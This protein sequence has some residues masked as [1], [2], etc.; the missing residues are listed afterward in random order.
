MK[1]AYFKNRRLWGLLSVIYLVLITFPGYY[2]PIQAGLDPSWVYG[3]NYLAQSD[4]VF[5]QDVVFTYG[6]LG[7]LIHPLNIGPNLTY[8]VALWGIIHSLFA[9]IL[10]YFLFRAKRLLPF[11]LFIIAYITTSV[12]GWINLYEYHFLLILGL[13]FCASFVDNNKMWYVAAPLGG[14]LAG[15]SL[16]M[17]LNLGLAALTMIIA[18]GLIWIIKNRQKAWQVILLS[19]GAYLLM[20]I[21]LSKV[22]FQ[23]FQNSIGWIKASLD[24]VSGYSAAM[25]IIGPR[26]HLF[27]GVL[28]LAIYI[29]LTFLLLRKRSNLFYAAFIFIV[30]IFFAFKHSFVRQDGHVLI[31][32]LFLLAVFS[33]L[34][35][36]T[37]GRKELRMV[38]SGFLAAL[39]LTL[40]VVAAYHSTSFSMAGDIISGGRG[41]SNINSVVRLENVRAQLDQQGQ[42]NLEKDRLPTEWVNEIKNNDNGMADA[43]PWEICYCPANNLS[44]NPNPVL[45]TYSAYTS[46]LDNWSASHYEGNNAPEF[47]IAEFMDIDGRHPL[48]G[49]PATWRNI[50]LNY[51]L[52]LKDSDAGRLLLERKTQPSKENVVVINRGKGYTNQWISVPRSNNLLFLDI[53]MQLT[54]LGAGIKTLFRIPPVYMDLIYDS[55]RGMSYRIIPD[56]A[57][58]GLLINFLP[59]N[60]EELSK[61]FTGV[62]ND[63]VAQ[64]RISGPGTIYYG[65]EISLTWK[66]ISYAIKFEGLLQF[67][68]CRF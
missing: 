25:S 51:E 60:A 17:K 48:L 57:K 2:R 53:D 44:W 30:P 12:I 4:Y 14:L 64:F 9:S 22:Y 26:I 16:F 36:N 47:L 34:I 10:F 23:S 49:T 27:L 67:L 37:I 59:S 15:L 62:A 39:I 29:A 33:V 13:L 20:V 54:F 18:Y 65:K 41:W 45:Q 5:G 68:N 50:I 43:V 61:L 24:I 46:F 1:F 38:I 19:G 21:F 28:A 8:W 40:P 52:T 11:F 7:Y 66:E 35:L 32:F 63:R 55:G 58:N 6:P 56:T 31:F 3:L 42:L